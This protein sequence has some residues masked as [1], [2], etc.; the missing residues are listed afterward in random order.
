MTT[1]PACTTGPRVARAIARTG[2]E[3]VSARSCAP[4]R[5]SST[6][7]P[8]ASAASTLP[9][10]GPPSAVPAVSRRTGESSWTWNSRAPLLPT[11]VTVSPTA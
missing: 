4:D 5:E 10:S 2:A 11:Y 8:F 7:F 1:F 6:T 9:L 3:K